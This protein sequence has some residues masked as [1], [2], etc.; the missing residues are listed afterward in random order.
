MYTSGNRAAK[1][2]G[3]DQALFSKLATGKRKLVGIEVS[4]VV[5]DANIT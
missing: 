2:M 3:I 5:V 1:A 4:F